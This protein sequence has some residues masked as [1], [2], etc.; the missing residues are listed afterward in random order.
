MLLSAL[1]LEALHRIL[2]FV[3]DND[4]FYLILT[5]SSV[6]IHKIK[7]TGSLSICWGKS[8]YIDFN[9][10]LP[11]IRAFP[12]LRSLR[13]TA[14]SPQ[15]LARTRL[16]R[17][18][19]P[20]SLNSLEL[21]FNDAFGI[22]QSVHCTKLFTSVPHLESL[23]ITSSAGVPKD[24]SLS[25]YGF[26]PN[27]RS[28]RLISR[29]MANIS[30]HS[31]DLR[32]LPPHLETLQIFVN[33]RRRFDV[34][35]LKPGS[36]PGHLQ[37]LTSLSIMLSSQYQLDTT[38]IGSSL[39]HL[40]T[41]S[42][43]IVHGGK[44]LSQASE[45][46]SSFYPSLVSFKVDCY[47]LSSWSQLA[48]M[49]PSLTALCVRCS[50]VEPAPNHTTSALDAINRDY[51]ELRPTFIPNNLRVFEN[52]SREDRF[53]SFPPGVLSYFPNLSSPV[54]GPI[55]AQEG[56][57]HLAPLDNLTDLTL[58]RVKLSWLASLPKGL[59][60]LRIQSISQKGSSTKAEAELLS[61][62]PEPLFPRVVSMK[63][64]EYFPT[65]LIDF[66]PPSLQSLDVPVAHSTL[67]ALSLRSVHLPHLTRLVIYSRIEKRNHDSLMLSLDTIPGT[68]TTLN[69]LKSYFQFPSDPSRSLRH[70]R[71]LKE[72]KL[73]DDALD[74]V[75]LLS[76]VPSSLT[77]LDAVLKC[78]TF[79]ASNLDQIT[80][81]YHHG[82]RLIHLKV[83]N[84]A[85]EVKVEHFGAWRLPHSYWSS[86]WKWLALPLQVKLGYWRAL[87]GAAKSTQSRSATASEIILLSCLPRNLAILR[88]PI[89]DY[90][91][92]RA[93]RPVLG[94]L[95]QHFIASNLKY[96]IPLLGLAI[97]GKNDYRYEQQVL[98]D[99][100][101]LDSLPRN[102]SK[103]SV[104][105]RHHIDS[106]IFRETTGFLPLDLYN[107]NKSTSPWISPSET[108]YHLI[109]LLTLLP[110]AVLGAQSFNKNF[111]FRGYML[112]GIIGSAICLPVSAWRWMTS[113]RFPIHRS[114]LP[115]TERISAMVV[116]AALN[117]LAYF[118]LQSS[119]SSIYTRIGAFLGLCILSVGR[120]M[121]LYNSRK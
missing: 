43:Q 107:D 53:V 5:G 112:S 46:L 83:L 25:L 71:S 76:N 111:L 117:A 102:L 52:L 105:A 96:Q 120:N 100:E 55:Q 16:D 26:P 30:Y 81:L 11:L 94:A 29:D 44:M 72:L 23:S 63:F 1:S 67:L 47:N 108:T 92:T 51:S 77:L 39:R 20:S 91:P 27:L 79:D 84:L 49:P 110:L 7:R 104:N 103:A 24:V 59:Q 38:M 17:A 89:V 109:N 75:D 64:D 35:T 42:G 73:R 2:Y 58:D 18:M 60:S 118:A 33:P 3:G 98:G 37:S 6:L 93:T 22:L 116:C 115:I 45:P 9:A 106:A 121:I 36:L 32:D 21:E 95:L 119:G 68:V 31:L 90:R 65:Q 40:E 28:L 50:M 12:D 56:L 70:H 10:C 62:S 13:L 66:L 8:S 61:Q 99:D 87:L 97:F 101:M 78:S 88:T 69:V 113:G 57:S 41:K 85:D 14:W 54:F 19:F 34:T 80:D 15:L 4:V 48:D 86:S 82:Q 74:I 114:K